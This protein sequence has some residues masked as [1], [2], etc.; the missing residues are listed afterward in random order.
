MMITDPG[1]LVHRARWWHAEGDALRCTLCPHRCLIPNGNTGFCNARANVSGQLVSLTYGRV[2]ATAVDPIEK[3]PVF[4][5]RPGARLYSVGTF[6]CNLDCDFCQNAVMARAHLDDIPSV[7]VTPD[8][9]VGTALEKQVD[10]IGWTFNDPVVWSEYIIDVSA[11]AHARG[12]FNLLNTNGYI[13]ARARD[14]LLADIDAVKVDIKGFEERTY[15]ELNGAALAPVL[16]TCVAIMVRDIHLELAYPV[17]PGWTD[18]PKTLVKFGNWVIEELGRDVPVHLFRFQPAHRL[19]HLHSPELSRMGEL[20][21]VLADRGLRFVYLGG[22]MGE[23]QDTRCTKC[24][25]VVISR[26]A[27]EPGEKIFVKKE[28]VSRFC[29]TFASVRSSIVDGCCPKCGESLPIRQNI[30][31][32]QA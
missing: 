28:Q 12:L 14:E 24:G 17:I 4:H 30:L 11:L 19:S 16:E 22:V 8:E 13:E 32:G 15:K 7:F 26:R 6:G 18:D 5:Y 23:D 9:M 31:S 20:K 27:E 29:P 25:S 10:G 2:C 1:P 3:K 21:E